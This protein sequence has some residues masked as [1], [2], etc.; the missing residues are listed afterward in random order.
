M[1]K[2]SI[3]QPYLNFKKKWQNLRKFLNLKDWTDT[4]KNIYRKVTKL[5]QLSRIARYEFLNTGVCYIIFSNHITLSNLVLLW[6]CWI[7]LSHFSDCLILLFTKYW[8]L[9]L[10][11]ISVFEQWNNISEEFFNNLLNKTLVYHFTLNTCSIP[12]HKSK[13]FIMYMQ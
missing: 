11:C 5:L 6:N 13:T 12:L 3:R 1:E 9:E 8:L 2:R 10:T 7:S 4:D